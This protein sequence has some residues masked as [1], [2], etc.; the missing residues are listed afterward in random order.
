MSTE[1]VYDGPITL[2][3]FLEARIVEDEL[4]ALAAREGPWGTRTDT[5]GNREIYSVPREERIGGD[6]NVFPDAWDEESTAHA[7]RHDPTRA[8]REVEAKRRGIESHRWHGPD[9]C[10]EDRFCPMLAAM[11]AV[12][13]NHPSYRQEWSP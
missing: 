1:P 9:G 3:E 6:S 10:G 8:L 4:A 7:V 11:A 5:I 13:A 2:L 12:Y